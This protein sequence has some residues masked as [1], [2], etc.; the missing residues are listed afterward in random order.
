MPTA[1]THAHAAARHS[2]LLAEQ[3]SSEKGPTLRPSPPPHGCRRQRRPAQGAASRPSSAA[4]SCPGFSWRLGGSGPAAPPLATAVF[5]A[6]QL[7]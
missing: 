7:D 3:L 5:L 4:T 6:E 2:C 1:A